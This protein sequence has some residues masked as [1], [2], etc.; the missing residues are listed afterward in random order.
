MLDPDPYP[1]PDSMNPDPQHCAKAE[2]NISHL[3]CN[4]K[5]D[6]DRRLKESNKLD[7]GA[8]LISLLA[9]AV[10]LS[11]VKQQSPSENN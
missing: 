10:S 8:C 7:G 9:A 2:K 11:S 5:T 4:L 6:D 3:S 1:D